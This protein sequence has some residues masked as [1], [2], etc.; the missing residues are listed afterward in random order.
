MSFTCFETE[1]LSSGKPLYIKVWYNVFYMHQYSLVGGK[2]CSTI[3]IDF[4]LPEDEI[5]VS[6]H[7]EGIEN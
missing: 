4:L 2:V 6:K 5:S 7:V 3:R 1:C